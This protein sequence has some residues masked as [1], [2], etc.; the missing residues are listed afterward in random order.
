[1]RLA[2]IAVWVVLL[3]W[4]LP[5]Q[6]GTAFHDPIYGVDVTSNILYG[7]GP[8]NADPHN[9]NLYLDLYRPIDIGQGALP[10]QSPG[11]VLIHGGGFIEGDKADE[12]MELVS[13][14]YASYGYIVASINYRLF[15][16]DVPA[17]T[18]PADDM[19]MPPAPFLSLPEP[20]GTQTVNAAVEDSAKAMRW[21]RDNA[22]LHHIDAKHIALGGF[23]A[24]AI[25]A[26]LEAYK[27]PVREPPQAVLSFIGAMYGTEGTIQAGGPPAFVVASR[28]DTKVPFDAPLGTQAMVDR[29]NTVGV[30]NEFYVQTIGH[31]VDFDAMMPDGQTLRKHNM[32]FL[33]HFLVPESWI[34]RRLWLV[35]LLLGTVVVS[36]G[37]LFIISRRRMQA[38]RRI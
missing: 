33:A 36:L 7:D 29:M 28:D 38:A 5:A 27:T 14:A 3:A 31:T 25:T 8:I 10:A 26:L 21:M 24:G 18:G 32:D 2:R 11:I 16:D 4:S 15:D 35:L 37:L 22:A 17:H 20:D 13:R 1:M 23:S 30:Y 34:Q 19:I 12:R 6:A 9:R